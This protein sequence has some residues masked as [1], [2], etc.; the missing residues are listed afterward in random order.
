MGERWKETFDRLTRQPVA[1]RP[2]FKTRWANWH[3]ST[4]LPFS[5]SVVESK[6]LSLLVSRPGEITMSSRRDDQPGYPISPSSG[7]TPPVRIQT[8]PFDDARFVFHTTIFILA[9]F[10]LFAVFTWPRLLTRFS[11]GSEW[12]SGHFFYHST[13]PQRRPPA[14]KRRPTISRPLEARYEKGLRAPNSDD[15][16]T[17]VSHTG[18]VRR[19]WE[20]DAKV[21]L[22]PHCKSWSGIFHKLSTILST[23]LD[24]GL[25]LGRCIILICY[26][27]VVLFASLYKSNPFRDYL[28][29]GFVSTAQI[30]IVFALGTKNNIIGRFLSMGY[31]K[32]KSAFSFSQ[33]LASRLI[34]NCI[35][36]SSITSI[37]SQGRLPYWLPTSTP[38][39]IVSHF[40]QYF[41]VA[42]IDAS[43]LSLRMDP[44]RNR[45]EKTPD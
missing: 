14:P 9:C 8:R 11:R 35:R 25:S 31:E 7:Y 6:Q 17:A 44:A 45:R 30:P 38:L 13:K 20:R 16:H 32:V 18:L 4:Y 23:R 26:F 3:T 40:S 19:E 41:L 12:T 22:P 39:A 1:L 28:R 21:S 43:H 33:F 34:F 42:A 36:S 24:D 15:D 10:A 5:F 29:T 27:S 2:P 37:V